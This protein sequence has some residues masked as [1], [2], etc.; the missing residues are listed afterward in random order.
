MHL[1]KFYSLQ[2]SFGQAC[3]DCVYRGESAKACC[4]SEA[5]TRRDSNNERNSRWKTRTGKLR[6]RERESI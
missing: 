2:S 4:S 5:R 6:D 1:K 3:C